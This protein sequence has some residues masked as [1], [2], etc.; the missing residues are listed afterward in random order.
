MVRL[1][2]LNCARRV[3]ML[4][5]SAP[6]NHLGFLPWILGLCT[7]FGALSGCQSE[8][9]TPRSYTPSARTT[10]RTT[11][12]QTA[13]SWRFKPLSWEKL[14]SIESWL[15]GAGKR[16]SSAL[17]LEAEFT[18][19]NGRLTF[20]ERDRARSSSG[21]I[22]TRLDAAS[23]GFGRILRSRASTALDRQKAREALQRIAKQRPRES[24]GLNVIPRSDWKPAN[25]RRQSLTR[26]SGAWNRVTVHHS[27]ELAGVLR[28]S[29][30]NESSDA[31]RKIQKYHQDTHGWGDIG[32]HYL[33]DP[34]GRIFEGRS[35]RWQ[36]AHAGANNNPHN[37]GICLLGNF[38]REA[39]SNSAMRSLESL[40]AQLRA[41]YGISSERVFGHGEL[42]TTAC[43][44]RHLRSWPVAY[45]ARGRSGRAL[46][47]R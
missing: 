43:P 32:Y 47:A 46:A 3:E 33:I 30:K 1:T 31:I 13:P 35:L 36:G 15:A 38:E 24:A 39:P 5:S 26:N 2:R 8:S 12:D 37:I 9:Y 22:A 28:R 20:A 18:L 11:R 7:L 23:A 19:A 41:R 27:A 21:T 45:R 44:G 4:T 40:V 42:K 6:R 16:A 25:E 29:S 14:E 34:S 10:R 17:Q